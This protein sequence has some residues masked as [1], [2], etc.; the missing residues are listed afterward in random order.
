MLKNFHIIPKN[1]FLYLLTINSPQFDILFEFQIIHALYSLKSFRQ[2]KN[3][4]SKLITRLIFFNDNNNKKTIYCDD[5][6]V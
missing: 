1:T 6:E 5:Y 2:K 3:P 4:F